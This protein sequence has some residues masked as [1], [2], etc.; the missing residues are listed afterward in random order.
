MS[1]YTSSKSWRTVSQNLGVAR[2]TLSRFINS[3]WEP[4][5][6]AIRLKLGLPLKEVPAQPCA[7][8][9]AVHLA[10]RCMADK[11]VPAYRPEV[12]KFIAWVHQRERAM[13]K[14]QIA[15]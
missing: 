2:T 4:H 15:Y 3:D 14:R 6:N 8:C 12:E 9:G 5:N 11:M 10:K 1:M 7:K 13:A